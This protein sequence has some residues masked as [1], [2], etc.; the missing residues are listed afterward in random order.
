ML[1]ENAGDTA[2]GQHKGKDAGAAE[3][4]INSRKPSRS[5]L[6]PAAARPAARPVLPTAGR[7]G[8]PRQVK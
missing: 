5:R 6:P 1:Q 3:V 2:A 7:G 4:G 8:N